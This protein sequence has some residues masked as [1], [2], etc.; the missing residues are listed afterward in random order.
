MATRTQSMA[1]SQHPPHSSRKNRLNSYARYSGLG[2]QMLVFIFAGMY[3]GYKLDR[4]LYL[5]FSAFTIF[6]CLLG[7]AIAI[8]LSIK[9]FTK[10]KFVLFLHEFFLLPE[11]YNFF[12]CT[13]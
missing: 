9:N 2:I 1:T 12:F 10:K 6:L 5:K 3:G 8:L 7:T 11:K 4:L 13:F